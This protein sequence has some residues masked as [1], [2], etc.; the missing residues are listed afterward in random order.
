M[1]FGVDTKILAWGTT[2]HHLIFWKR[3]LS[4]IPYRGLKA[5]F[6]AFIP[7]IIAIQCIF[8]DDVLSEISSAGVDL[9]IANLFNH[10]FI[11]DISIIRF[12][13]INKAEFFVE[14]VLFP[15][16]TDF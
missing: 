5:L 6:F 11:L 16:G 3:Q 13:F 8:R 7:S 12:L 2:S 15:L 14:S 1:L 10:S 4:R 9:W